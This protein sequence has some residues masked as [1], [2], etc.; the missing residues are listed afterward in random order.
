M[1]AQTLTTMDQESVERV[2]E[3]Q[4]DDR[5]ILE[6]MVVFFYAFTY[7]DEPMKLTPWST[8]LPTSMIARA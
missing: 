8:L 7:N 2:V 4:E 1:A 3:L 5:E 6:I